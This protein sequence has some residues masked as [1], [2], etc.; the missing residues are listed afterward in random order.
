MVSAANRNSFPFQS[1]VADSC[2]KTAKDR[3]QNQ[4]ECLVNA[5]NEAFIIRK[6]SE[7]YIVVTLAHAQ[8]DADLNMQQMYGWILLSRVTL[9]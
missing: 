2:I 3:K 9:S 7:I 5:F 8:A 1:S 6:T 4:F